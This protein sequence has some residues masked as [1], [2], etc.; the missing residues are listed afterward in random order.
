MASTVGHVLTGVA[1]G[2]AILPRTTS[3]R[4][5]IAGVVC[6]ALPDIDAIGRPFGWGDV[7][8]L[9]GHR[10]LT[11][12]LLFALILGLLVTLMWFRD[13]PWN[14][15]HTRIALYLVVATAAHGVLDAFTSYGPGV[16]FFF[17]F[18]STRYVSAWRPLQAANEIAWVWLPTIL[19]ITA[20]SWVRRSRGSS[21]L[22]VQAESVI[23]T[24]VRKAS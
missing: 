10:G 19:V 6:A 20:G 3:R 22:D 23:S 13:G 8:F 14:K 17:P 21:H 24:T 7:A 18:S 2:T 15:A 4:V 16:A 1:F 5:W 12:S 11:H 9:G